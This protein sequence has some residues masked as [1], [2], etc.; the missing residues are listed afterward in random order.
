MFIELTFLYRTT[1]QLH[2]DFFLITTCSICD[3][4]VSLAV[5][6]CWTSTPVINEF[7]T[8]AL[9]FAFVVEFTFCCI[10]DPFSSNNFDGLLAWVGVIGLPSLISSTIS[11]ASLDKSPSG[12]NGLSQPL[13]VL[14]IKQSNYFIFI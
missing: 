2:L 9:P 3:A 7:S 8:G 12:R 5:V 11:S 14:K 1:Q 13:S 4:S 10:A 6:P